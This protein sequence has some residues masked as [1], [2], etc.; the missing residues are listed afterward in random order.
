MQGQLWKWSEAL[1]DI[2]HGETRHLDGK[3]RAMIVV[4][5][6]EREWVTLSLTVERNES[7]TTLN[8]KHDS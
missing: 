5:E 1:N 8:H 2:E 3:V 7:D 4:H 6:R